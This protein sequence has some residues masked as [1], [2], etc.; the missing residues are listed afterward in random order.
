MMTVLTLLGAASPR[1]TGEAVAGTGQDAGFAGLVDEMQLSEAVPEAVPEGAVAALNDVGMSETQPEEAE[2]TSVPVMPDQVP[3]PASVHPLAAQMLPIAGRM[4]PAAGTTSDRGRI[5]LPTAA[6]TMPPVFD[7]GFPIFEG[8]G[9]FLS[10]P[11]PD[12]GDARPAPPTDDLWSP[13]APTALPDLETVGPAPPASVGPDPAGPA[14][15]D[16][17]A[18]AR[19]AQVAPLPATPVEDAVGRP[20][21]ATATAAAAAGATL[22]EPAPPDGQID[23]GTTAEVLRAAA[24]SWVRVERV[25][26]GKEG[27][28]AANLGRMPDALER[29]I[30]AGADATASQPV[31]AAATA[32]D[33]APPTRLPAAEDE[34]PDRAAPMPIADAG[35]DAPDLRADLSPATVQTTAAQQAIA[36]ATALPPARSP[37]VQAALD[38]VLPLP[39]AAGET[40]V[41]L[42]PQGLGMIEVV[43]QENRHGTLDVTLRVQNPLVLDAMRQ[44][45]DAVA[46]ALANAQG[47]A[48]GSLSMDLFHA[49]TGQRG[50]EPEAPF[51]GG[52]AAEA[53]PELVEGATDAPD[54]QILRAD[55]VNIVT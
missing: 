36:A 25:T 34:L 26:P 6:V 39:A 7:G 18:A 41:R 44:D 49:G 31:P 3:S 55:R 13:V 8:A 19:I 27:V 46:Q 29:R 12:V 24:S 10:T 37:L 43:V 5:E 11:S 15:P 17:G 9:P 32:E 45:R 48:A 22:A 21:P 35:P 53:D 54:L 14:A 28:I 30:D 1:A 52:A 51:F 38:R 4:P 16:K 47:G 2:E 20:P 42:D 33:T 23:A 40:V 50:A